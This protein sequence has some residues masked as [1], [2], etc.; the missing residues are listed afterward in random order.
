MFLFVDEH[1]KIRWLEGKV[2]ELDE[3]LKTTHNQAKEVIERAS[4][5]LAQAKLI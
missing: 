1:V 4:E 5:E 3:A 2:K